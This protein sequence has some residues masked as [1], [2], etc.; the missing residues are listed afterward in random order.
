MATPVQPSRQFVRSSCPLCGLDRAEGERGAML[1]CAGC[2]LLMCADGCLPNRLSPRGDKQAGTQGRSRAARHFDRIEAYGDLTPA[3]RRGKKLLAIG[4][5]IAGVLEEARGRGY[6]ATGVDNAESAAIPGVFDV[7]VLADVVERTED[8]LATA[9]RGWDLL[10]PDGTVFV[11]F[12]S[13]GRGSTNLFY[14]DRHTAESLL[15]RAGFDRVRIA[16]TD[17]IEGL[18]RRTAQGPIDR[19]CPML[20]VVMPVF[21][22]RATFSEIVTRLLS[23]PLTGFGL[24]L[25]VVESNST[26]GT[27]EE[28]RR[29]EGDPRVTVVYE[30]RPRGKGHAVRAGLDRATGDFVLIQDA[31]LEYD[32]DDYEL[33]LEPLRTCRH[34]LVL[35]SRHG[36]NGRSWRLRLFTEQRV[37]SRIM[38]LGHVCFTWFFNAVYGTR[39]RDPFTM[40]KVFRRDCLSGLTFESNRFDFD[41]ELLAKLVRAGYTPV[42]IPIRYRSRSYTEGKKVRF[43]RDPPTWVRACLKYRFVRLEK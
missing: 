20:S 43:W 34:A 11:T 27:R 36:A 30:D 23:K 9:V 21:N 35:G 10:A 17:G 41:W 13:R 29:F 14:F 38:N 32:L 15:V 6:H 3:S 37:V 40:Y 19:R 26:D 18:A 8:P 2:S 25:I 39:L 1:R 5:D 24:Q 16:A 12:H 22:E 33:L 4:S 7:C 31:D 28:V 42:E